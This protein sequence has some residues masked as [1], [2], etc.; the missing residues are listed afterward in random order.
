MHSA[1][2]VNG[3]QPWIAPNSLRNTEPGINLEIDRDRISAGQVQRDPQW[4]FP[5]WD[6]D[7]TAPVRAGL[8]AADDVDA[9]AEADQVDALVGADDEVPS[10]D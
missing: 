4:T 10:D 8:D 9:D 2:D 5:T 3:V 1:E 7:G 6:D